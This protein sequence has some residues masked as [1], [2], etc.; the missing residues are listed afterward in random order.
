MIMLPAQ[1]KSS[2]MIGFCL[3]RRPDRLLASKKK[4]D[5][6]SFF[7]Q[8]TKRWKNV[9]KQKTAG[10]GIAGG[11]H[12]SESKV[13]LISP[14]LRTLCSYRLSLEQLPHPSRPLHRR[15]AWRVFLNCW[16]FILLVGRPPTWNS[17]NFVP[18][19]CKNIIISCI[20]EGCFFRILRWKSS[21]NA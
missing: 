8:M 16:H 11:T 9:R 6:C 21:V 13:S 20:D 12:C 15:R 3:F 17:L 4:S 1:I 19:S 10:S 5:M 7:C 18:P 14:H 2:E